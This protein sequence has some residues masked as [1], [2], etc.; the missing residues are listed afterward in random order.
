MAYDVQFTGLARRALQGIPPR[1]VPAIIEFAF[2]DLR[3]SHTGSASPL[4]WI[5]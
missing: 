2:G 4:K 5:G 3:V 1:V